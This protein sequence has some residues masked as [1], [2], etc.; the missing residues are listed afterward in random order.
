MW[1]FTWAGSYLQWYCAFG[2]CILNGTFSVLP[3][4]NTDV[5]LSPSYLDIFK[6]VLAEYI[7]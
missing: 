3:A 4:Q 1:D 6:A 2:G 5:A 7:L